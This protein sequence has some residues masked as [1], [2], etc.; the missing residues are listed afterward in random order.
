MGSISSVQS[1]FSCARS[2]CCVVVS[3]CVLCRQGDTY[4]YRVFEAKER[5]WM[6]FSPPLACMSCI[7]PRPATTT[8]DLRYSRMVE[9]AIM[10]ERGDTYWHFFPDVTGLLNPTNAA[11]VSFLF[12]SIHTYKIILCFR[13]SVR[14]WFLSR[15][16]YA[17]RGTGILGQ[18]ALLERGLRG[19]APTSLTLTYPFNIS[20]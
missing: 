9:R 10:Y 15:P 12:R 20:T 13:D 17:I 1:P 7:F 5:T 14:I 4:Y 3:C 16:K 2:D 6:R 8:M 18:I 19:A 11:G